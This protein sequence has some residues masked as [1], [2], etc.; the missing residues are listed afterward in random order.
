MQSLASISNHTAVPEDMTLPGKTNKEPK[1]YE[2]KELQ[3]DIKNENH[4][5]HYL[6]EVIL[7]YSLT[8]MHVHNHV[9][10]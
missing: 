8:I 2:L 4:E 5:Y 10:V 1:Y 6:E 7:C 3:C 9:L